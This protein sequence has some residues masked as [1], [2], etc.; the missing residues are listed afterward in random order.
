MVLRSGQRTKSI[1]LFEF[2][3]CLSRNVYQVT[4]LG[5]P[6]EKLVWSTPTSWRIEC[7][8]IWGGFGFVIFSCG[9]V[10]Q[11]NVVWHVVYSLPPDSGHLW[12]GF[13][14]IGHIAQMSRAFSSSSTYWSC[15]FQSGYPSPIFRRLDRGCLCTFRTSIWKWW[16]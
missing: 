13:Q 10:L 11:V 4:A 5:A 9:T 8:A 15:A 16:P 7:N 3:A 6:K 1:S 2:V 14:L 12:P